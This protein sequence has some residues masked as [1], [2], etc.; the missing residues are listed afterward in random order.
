MVAAR[1]T[2]LDNERLKEDSVTVKYSVLAQLGKDKELMQKLKLGT[3]HLTLPSSKLSLVSPQFGL[4]E[5]PFLI[6]DR[7]HLSIA[8]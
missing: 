4:F 1:F 3:I 7:K 6:K 8:Q 2:E 5:M